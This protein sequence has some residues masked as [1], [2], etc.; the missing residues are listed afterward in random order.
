MLGKLLKQL[1]L[2]AGKTASE[3]A[4]HI[5]PES[6]SLVRVLPD[7]TYQ[8]QTESINVHNEP[9]A[10]TKLVSAVKKG[11]RVHLALSPEYY[12]LVQLDKPAVA[13]AEILQ[14]LPWQVKDLVSIAPEDMVAD[15][16]DVPGT[17][18]QTAK[19]NVVVASISVLKPLVS[20]LVQ[21]GLKLMS[22]QPE[23]WLAAYLQPAQAHAAMLVIQQPGQEVLIQI[24]KD[25]VLYFSRRTR[26]FNRMQFDTEIQLQNDWMDRLQLEL[27]RSMDY[28]EGQLKQ[29]PVR[30]IGLLMPNAQQLSQLLS[31][32]GFSRVSTLTPAI[33]QNG[34]SESELLRC[35]PAIALLNQ[36]ARD[37]A[38]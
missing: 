4:I 27:Q 14:A 10:L 11:S 36:P 38:A 31:N 7:G 12:Q 6:V 24:I 18:A 23:E 16:T 34:C 37:N 15:Y 33:T 5:N 30:E 9:E 26:G 35:W 17:A 8:A 13:E 21:A 3:V 2:T 1:N 19:I 22:I 32:A 29:A 28:F 25:G 20:K